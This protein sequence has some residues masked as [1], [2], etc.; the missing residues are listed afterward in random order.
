MTKPKITPNTVPYPKGLE[1]DT[2]TPPT[3]ESYRYL[4]GK[5]GERPLFAICMN[6]SAARDNTS[7]RT[8]NRVIQA[9]ISLGYQ[10]WF[11]ANIYPERATDATMLDELNMQHIEENVRIVQTFLRE[12]NIKEVWGAW[13][14]TK[15]EHLKKGKEAMVSMLKKENIR[16]FAFQI[17]ASGNPKHPLYLKIKVENKMYLP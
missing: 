15:Q 7:D 10:G 3:Y 6:P 11:V 17:N 4:I 13:G 8:V 14:E 5:R 12:N 16:I 9:S 1:P 2:V